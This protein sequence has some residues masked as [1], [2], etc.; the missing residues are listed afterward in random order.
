VDS[1]TTGR[2]FGTYDTLSEA[3]KRLR[4][5]EFLEHRKATTPARGR[6]HASA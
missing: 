1:K 2:R 5:I 6:P 4:E 3:K